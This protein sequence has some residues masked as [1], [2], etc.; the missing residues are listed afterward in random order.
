MQVSL[1]QEMERVSFAQHSVLLVR[2]ISN[3]L[4]QLLRFYTY[5]QNTVSEIMV[6]RNLYAAYAS[7]YLLQQFFPVFLINV[8][9]KY[10][11]GR[12]YQPGIFSALIKK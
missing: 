7:K 3:F 8:E 5:C 2:Y 12:N 11:H 10:V 1:G 9:C 4:R 6:A